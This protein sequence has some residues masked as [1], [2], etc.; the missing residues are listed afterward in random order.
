MSWESSSVIFVFTLEKAGAG[1]LHV[2]VHGA[3]SGQLWLLLGCEFEVEVV[4]GQRDAN[5]EAKDE[6]EDQRK[7]FLQ[8]FS[9][10]SDAFKSCKRNRHHR[11]LELCSCVCAVIDRKSVV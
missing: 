2:L 1:C 9:L 4:D 5:D 10:V 3:V 7:G 11:K 6:A 8:S